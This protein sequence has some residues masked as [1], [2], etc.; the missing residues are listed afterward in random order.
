MGQKSSQNN[1]K[2]KS[3]YFRLI[4]ILTRTE[5]CSGF[6]L[7]KKQIGKLCTYNYRSLRNKPGAWSE[8]MSRWLELLL[9]KHAEMRIKWIC[10]NIQMWNSH[11]EWS[12]LHVHK[13]DVCKYVACKYGSR[14]KRGEEDELTLTHTRKIRLG[15]LAKGEDL[16][17]PCHSLVEILWEKLKIHCRQYLFKSKIESTSINLKLY[18][19]SQHWSLIWAVPAQPISCP[20]SMPGNEI[21]AA[22][23]CWGRWYGPAWVCGPAGTQA[24]HFHPHWTFH[25]TFDLSLG[26]VLSFPWF[27]KF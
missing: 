16:T 6:Y 23:W 12:G 14:S 21:S 4:D 26:T 7:L 2:A 17:L 5:F 15:I 1:G 22:F 9:E 24:A 18:H 3:S 13:N 10:N 25:L 20:G 19:H 27:H 11:L 8:H